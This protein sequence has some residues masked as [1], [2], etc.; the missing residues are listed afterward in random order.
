MGLKIAAMAAVP[1]WLA[2]SIGGTA[3]A[4][5]L[6]DLP[7]VGQV[8]L[9]LSVVYYTVEGRRYDDAVDAM[10]EAGPNGYQAETRS[11]FT[12][13]MRYQPTARGCAITHLDLPLDV[14]IL[15]PQ[16][17]GYDRA[18]RR[19]REAW[20][21]HMDVLTVHENIHAVIAFLGT[22]EMYN[23]L[24][25]VGPQTDCETLDDLVRTRTREANA[26]LQQWQQDYDRVT[27]HGEDQ[28]GFD[29]HAFM[30]ERL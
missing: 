14:E 9:T 21:R 16:W 8:P 11:Q 18:R 23:A 4:Q 26:R 12:Y 22:I 27:N 28:H 10:D 7:E 13:D 17:T 6:P 15:Y 5:D 30:G 1:V 24:V 2:A 3:S 19:D 29:L 20:D 25:Q